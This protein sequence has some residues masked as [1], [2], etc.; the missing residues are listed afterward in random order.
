[1]WLSEPNTSVV[2]KHRWLLVLYAYIERQKCKLVRHP[3]PFFALS[4]THDDGKMKEAILT[5]EIL[6]KV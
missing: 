3:W 6:D 1:M 5:K 2:V 4:H